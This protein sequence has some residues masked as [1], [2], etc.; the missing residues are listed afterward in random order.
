MGDEEKKDEYLGD[1]IFWVPK[2]ARWE[3]IKAHATSTDIGEIIDKAME[4]IEK[5]NIHCTN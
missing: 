4:T 2:E 5:E 3:N 1:N